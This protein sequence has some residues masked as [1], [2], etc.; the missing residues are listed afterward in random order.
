MFNKPLY[1]ESEEGSST[2][3]EEDEFGEDELGEEEDIADF[4][5]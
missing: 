3:S 1:S 2:R 5:D 4:E